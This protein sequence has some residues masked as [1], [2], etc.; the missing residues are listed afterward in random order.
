M[1]EIRLTIRLALLGLAVLAMTAPRTVF[2][3]FGTYIAVGDSLAFGE[4]DFTNNP[5]NGDRGY[6]APFADHL[7]QFYGGR[8]TVINLGLDSETSTTFFNGG[9]P[10]DGTVPGMPGY[11]QNTNYS[12]PF[13]PGTTQHGMLFSIINDQKAAGNTID[14]VSIQLG[15]NDLFVLARSP[16][17]FDTLTPAEQQAAVGQT[18]ATIQQNNFALLTE[19]RQA[20]PQTDI[21]MMGYLDPFAPFRN[22]PSSPLFPIAQASAGAIPAL[23]QINAGLATQFNAHYIDTYSLFVGNE[24]TDTSIADGGNVHPNAAGYALIAGAMQAVP[25]P[26]SLALVLIG[27]MGVP[28]LAR[29]RSRVAARV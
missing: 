21:V 10:G 24:L 9:T 8:P 27:A 11:V 17:F 28:G 3:G 25:E 20:L 16:G 7:A 22:D 5:S 2:A 29:R 4:T 1:H 19:L 13:P 18:L 26:A 15:G 14:A 23:N 6:V 12:N